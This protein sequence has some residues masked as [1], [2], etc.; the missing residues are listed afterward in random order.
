MKTKRPSAF[1]LLDF[2]MVGTPAVIT[3]ALALYVS[4]DSHKLSAPMLLVALAFCF[5][6][7]ALVYT[8]LKFL[9]KFTYMTSQ[10]VMVNFGSYEITG[11]DVENEVNRAV[12]LYT[13][14]FSN[15]EELL[16]SSTLW[17]TFKLGP[18]EDPVSRKIKLAGFITYGGE[19]AYVGYL[20]D[21]QLIE[22][23]ALAHE[24]GHIIMGRAT[25]KWDQDKDHK[26]MADN[27]L[28]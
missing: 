27:N 11:H 13:K 6:Y 8:R 16:E 23:T 20:S 17:L 26:F 10:G 21:D 22:T 2:L 12:E 9:S 19:A 15:A 3:S 25:K 5:L 28:P 7:G 14:Y 24:I 18:F 1:K 4:L